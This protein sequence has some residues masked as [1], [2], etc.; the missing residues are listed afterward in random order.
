MQ[1]KKGPR[2]WLEEREGR[3]PVWTIRD[4]KEKRSLGLSEFEFEEAEQQLA[5]YIG[6]KHAP[7]AYAARSDKIS[8]P[9]VLAVYDQRLAKKVARDNT[10]ATRRSV[11]TRKIHI[12]NLLTFWSDKTVADVKTSIC[13]GYEE[14]RQSIP[15]GRGM[16][17]GATKVSGS[18]IR[19]EL[20]TLGQAIK[21]WHGESPL[22][23]L[24]IVWTPPPAPPRQRH[25]ER[26]EVARL[27]RAAR[28]LG[29]KHIARYILLGVYTA[30]RDEAIRDLSWL[31]SS[32]NGWID[33]E[34]GVLYRAGFAEPQTSKRRPPMILPDRLLSHLRYWQVSDTANRIAHVITYTSP[35]PS[36]PGAIRR[37]ERLGRTARK[38][39]PVGDIHKAWASTVKLAGLGPDVT[40]HVLKHTAITWMLWNDLSIWDIAEDTGTSAKTIEEVYG[41]HR[42][43]ESRLNRA[44]KRRA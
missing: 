9:E 22:P 31:R 17:K 24:P 10:P 34:R 13:E 20:K 23:A 43:V 41:H 8:I 3:A 29:Y 14:Y 4:G 39:H 33:V 36:H 21:A 18:T 28:K 25:L 12:A 15:P 26:N 1:R 37:A 40:P 7:E 38:P 16:R 35:P 19:Q 5:E 11:A 42:S 30:T 6:Q 32:H 2:L 27:L 44:A